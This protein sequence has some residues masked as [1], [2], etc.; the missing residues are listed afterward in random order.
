MSSAEPL[1]IVDAVDIIHT[2]PGESRESVPTLAAIVGP[3]H[4]ER[5][6]PV[7]APD[8]S[9]SCC[10]RC[11][12]HFSTRTRRHHCRYCGM[13]LCS[14]CCNGGQLRLDR[15]LSSVEPHYLVS[16]PDHDLT[17]DQSG[18]PCG[19]V[20]VA[21]AEFAPAEIE[22]RLTERLRAVEER[23]AT[24]AAQQSFELE[25][26]RAAEQEELLHSRAELVVACE[27]PAG[28]DTIA[29]I[30][31]LMDKHPADP[32]IQETG[33]A[34]LA[35]KEWCRLAV[36]SSLAVR[37]SVDS[38]RQTISALRRA[39]RE[40]KTETVLCSFLVAVRRRTDYFIDKRGSRIVKPKDREDD[41]QQILSHPAYR[42][43]LIDDSDII[44]STLS[45][46][47]RRAILVLPMLARGVPQASKY[48]CLASAAALAVNALCMLNKQHEE[49]E[50]EEEEE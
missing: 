4:D 5:V 11:S 20:C 30:L 31:R 36:I 6:A 41:L 33:C 46:V 47:R 13:L 15:W 40:V 34:M 19:I 45:D 14:Q 27:E 26:Q 17:P 21:C 29:I 43:A 8:A 32:E 9:S 16:V 42:A 50:E 2:V 23:R 3:N 48:S 1:L 39:L 44:D 24:A 38:S 18:L 49:E 35:K 10:T 22:A 37:R 12:Q 28:H 25:G 7:W